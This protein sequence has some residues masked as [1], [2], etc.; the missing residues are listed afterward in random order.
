MAEWSWWHKTSWERVGT[1]SSASQQLLEQLWPLRF[2]FKPEQK[3]RAWNGRQG[4]RTTL[5]KGRVHPYHPT[6][7]HRE[8]GTE[9]PV[10]SMLI[11][12]FKAIYWQFFVTLTRIEVDA[13]P[14]EP[15]QI[16]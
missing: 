7:I 13:L 16:I 2:N 12:L 11:L 4:W 10:G 6:P 9:I 3:M 1:S 5:K 15:R 14:K 8:L